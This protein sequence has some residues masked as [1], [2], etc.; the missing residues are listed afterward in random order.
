MQCLDPRIA[1]TVDHFVISA[2]FPFAVALFRCRCGAKAVEYDLKR[3]APTG[4]S[5]VDTGSHRCPRCSVTTS[6]SRAL[7][8]P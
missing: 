1:Y 8:V 4:W 5:I 3:A 2:P 7:R 6:E